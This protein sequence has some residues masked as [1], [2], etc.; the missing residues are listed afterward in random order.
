MCGIDVP[1]SLKSD[2]RH[3]KKTTETDCLNAPPPVHFMLNKF[4]IRTISSTWKKISGTTSVIGE[5]EMLIIL[6]FAHD[7]DHITLGITMV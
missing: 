1:M 3:R 4:G 2:V 6:T 5:G 7:F